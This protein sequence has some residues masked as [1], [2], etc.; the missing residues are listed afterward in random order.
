MSFQHCLLSLARNGASNGT[1]R[2]VAAFLT[3]R[4]MVVKV[5]QLMSDPRQVNGGCPQGSI[6]EVF[7]FNATIDDLEK[8]CADLSEAP[9]EDARWAV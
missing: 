7:L 3:G 4:E 8:G 6:L 1:L 5:G 9:K 2:L